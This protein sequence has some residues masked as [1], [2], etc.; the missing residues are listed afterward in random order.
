MK[1]GRGDLI[2]VFTLSVL[3]W[4]FAN[5]LPNVLGSLQQKSRSLDAIRASGELVVLTQ[6][7]PTTYY[8]DKDGQERGPEYEI[9]SHFAQYLGVKPVFVIKNSVAELLDAIAGEEGDIGMAGLS[10]TQDRKRRFLF[11]PVYQQV[12]QQVVCRRGGAQPKSASDLLGLDIAVIGRSSYEERLKAMKTLY[13]DLVWQSTEGVSAEKLLEM[14][15]LKT[16]ACTVMD[17][18]IVSVNQRYFPELRVRFD[19][20]IKDS[21]AWITPRTSYAHALKRA[22]DDWFYE[23]SRSGELDDISERYYGHVKLFDYV[24]TRAFIRRISLRHPKYREHFKAAAESYGLSE[25]LLAAQ[26]YQESHWNPYARS[27]TGV[28]GIMMLTLPTAKEMGVH[29]RLDA[30]QSIFGGARYFAKLKAYLSKEVVE[31]DLIWLALA[32]YNV[33]L[34][35]LKDAQSLARQLNKDPYRWLDIKSVLPLLSDRRYYKKLK[36]GYARG[37]EPVRYVQQIREYELI[38]VQQL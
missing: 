28:R 38:L 35:H 21:L 24:D 30:E 8:I 10:I 25:T 13:P 7:N 29:S 12:S 2:L 5:Y 17:S 32:A 31:P 14:V 1:L 33:G 11:G 22:A 37:S 4:G 19:L 6:N 26:A 3:M 20:G 15:W 9:V 23:F 16:V 36:Y 18:N 34:G 27:P